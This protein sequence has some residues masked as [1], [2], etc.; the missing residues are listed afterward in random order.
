MVYGPGFW[1]RGQA[2]DSQFWVQGLWLR[3]GLSGCEVRALTAWDK[4]KNMISEYLKPSFRRSLCPT[5]DSWNNPTVR[6]PMDAE[7]H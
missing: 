4:R 1:V 3:L 6:D 7:L 5:Q 2:W